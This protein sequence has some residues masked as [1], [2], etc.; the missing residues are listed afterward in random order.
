[1]DNDFIKATTTTNRAKSNMYYPYIL[2]LEDMLSLCLPKQT[3]EKETPTIFAYSLLYKRP[4]VYVA[5]RKSCNIRGA[6]TSM[7]SGRRRVPSCPAI[8]HVDGLCMDRI[9]PYFLAK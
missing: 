6:C 9:S 4:F 3:S 7:L 8:F 1:M 2:T 5:K